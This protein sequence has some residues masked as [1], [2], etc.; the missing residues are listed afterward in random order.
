MR[1][2][3]WSTEGLLDG[4]EDDA[5]RAAR[6]RLLDT[7][8]AD[9]VTVAELRAAIAED[10][11]VLVPIER[12]LLAP[13]RYTLA[14]VAERAGVAIE[15]ADRRLRTLGVTIPQDPATAAFG[16][17]SSPRSGAAGPSGSRGWTRRDGRALTHLMSGVMARVAEPMRSLFAQ[18][19]LQPGD[20]EAE[21]A[22]R[23]GDRVYA[24]M[25]LVA[26]DLDYMLRM[27]LR[28]FA[29]SD[30]ISNAAR[31]TGRLPEGN[32]VAVAFVDIVG[33]TALGEELP[34]ADLTDIAG[35]L[36]SI[37]EAHVGGAVRLVKTIGDAV[38]VVSRDPAALTAAM[39]ALADAAEADADLP[40]VRTGIAWG[41][42][43]G[44]LGDYYGHA[45]N[46]ASRLTARA[47]PDSILVTNPLREALGDAAGNY[48]FSAAGMKRFKGIA[49]P[50]PVL[51]LR[52]GTDAAD[53]AA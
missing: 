12:A 48:S 24:L 46:L 44:R 25:P 7:L 42:A 2:M 31:A 45:V 18:A 1:S 41:R 29:R 13:A 20:D 26:A 36:E 9:G 34:E 37:A 49:D 28:D 8:H 6:V 16:T 33:F 38:M 51:R 30:A 19:Y 5:A 52:S 40:S 32:E 14:E 4:L 11:L 23:Y 17:T 53:D 3:D 47:R 21:L 39:V 27:H 15:L 10:R 43:V 50:V 35:R 22:L